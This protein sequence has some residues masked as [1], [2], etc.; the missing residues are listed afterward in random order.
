VGHDLLSEAGTTMALISLVAVGIVLGL[1]FA[2]PVLWW[3]GLGMFGLWIM[4]FVIRGVGRRW[5]AW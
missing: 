5:Y 3:V 1:G 2:M 4:G